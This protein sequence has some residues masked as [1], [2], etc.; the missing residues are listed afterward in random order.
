[1]LL[2]KDGMT[3][4]RP[5]DSAQTNEI[6]VPGSPGGRHLD[7]AFYSINLGIIRLSADGRRLA[8]TIYMQ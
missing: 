8:Y 3:N 6:D 5:G 4:E 7:T 2:N 1:M